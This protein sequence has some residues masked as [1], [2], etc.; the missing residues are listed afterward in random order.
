VS[1]PVILVS[2]GFP[3]Y[4]DYLGIAYARPLEAAGAVLLHLPFLAHVG[5]ALAVADGVLLGF[6]SDIDPARYGGEPHPTMTAP[7][8]GGD[9][10]R[11]GLVRASVL[12]DGLRPEHPGHALRVVLGSRLAVVSATARRAARPAAA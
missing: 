2:A 7:H 9:W 12:G 3:A 8:P 1:A 5:R 10:A 11:W 4:G 6:G